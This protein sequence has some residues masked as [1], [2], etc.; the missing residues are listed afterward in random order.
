MF[1]EVLLAMIMAPDAVASIRAPIS[2]RVS[3]TDVTVAKP[4]A[5]VTDKPSSLG[6]IL[7]HRAEK[8]VSMHG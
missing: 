1:D 5:C 2:A 8:E 4:D 3:A 6:E 7:H